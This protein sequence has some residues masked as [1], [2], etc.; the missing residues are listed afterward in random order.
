MITR[1]T[2]PL[3]F[4]VATVA[5]VLPFIRV[6]G[7]MPQRAPRYAITN[8]KIVTAAGPEIGRAHV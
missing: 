8:A 5:M 6:S 1:T 4:A 3:V 2:R 7:Q